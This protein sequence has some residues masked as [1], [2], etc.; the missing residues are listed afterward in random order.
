M[1]TRAGATNILQAVARHAKDTI[2]R[3]VLTSSN[4]A[5]MPSMNYITQT[6]G[7][8]GDHVFSEAE[9]NS[10]DTLSSSAYHTSKVR[11][12]G[13]SVQVDDHA[14]NL[15]QRRPGPAYC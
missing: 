14:I 13:A 2:R 9:W 12:V 6:G 15:V 7:T 11:S 4:A 1:L 5:V 8:Y 3:I 10:V